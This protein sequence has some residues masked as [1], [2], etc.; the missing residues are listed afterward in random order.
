MT[1][2]NLT[3]DSFL[4]KVIVE[5]KSCKV[6]S[7]DMTFV[8]SDG[9]SL[10]C[11]HEQ[12]C[13]ECVEIVDICGDIDDLL[14]SPLTQCEEVTNTD[15]PTEVVETSSCEKSLKGYDLTV[16]DDE[17]WTFYKFA[18]IK[19]SVTIRWYGSSNG[20]YS[21]SV[22]CTYTDAQNKTHDVG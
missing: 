4:G 14:G 15:Q 13:C 21:V 8:F 7:S 6:E 5:I 2:E 20:Y 11:Y 19:G 3:F 1:K 18:T 10:R 12:E 9:T 22:T 17:E 16:D